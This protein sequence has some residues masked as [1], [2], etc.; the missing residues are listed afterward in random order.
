MYRADVF[1]MEEE[2]Y[3]PDKKYFSIE[4]RKAQFEKK[5]FWGCMLGLV[6]VWVFVL[7]DILI[8]YGMKEFGW[9]YTDPIL[10]AAAKGAVNK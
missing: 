1:D 10:N 6:L 2:D 3:D 8:E 9:A 7:Q 5:L 4:Q